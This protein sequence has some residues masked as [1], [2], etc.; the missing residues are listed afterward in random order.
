[1]THC[2][3]AIGTSED[4]FFTLV[5]RF[6]FGT[7]DEKVRIKNLEVCKNCEEKTC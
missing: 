5:I 3:Y 4:T 2:K 1:M 6:L 7:P